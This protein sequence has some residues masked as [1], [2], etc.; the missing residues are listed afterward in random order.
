MLINSVYILCIKYE[1]IVNFNE[2]RKIF[3]RICINDY[4]YYMSGAHPV[5]SKPKISF[6]KIIGYTIKCYF[7]TLRRLPVFPIKISFSDAEMRENSR[8][9]RLVDLPAVDLCE[10]AHR[11]LEIHTCKVGREPLG[12]RLDGE[13]DVICRHLK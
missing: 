4:I 13:R 6:V 10:L 8:D 12:E 2:L 11:K 9:D 5:N 1:Q 3:T 7:Y